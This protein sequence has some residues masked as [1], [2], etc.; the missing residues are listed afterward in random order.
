MCD[1]YI[2]AKQAKTIL[3]HFNHD[4]SEKR[5][6]MTILLTR[7][8]DPTK[9]FLVIESNLK[10]GDIE[11]LEY[12]MGNLFYFTS[13]N[14]TGH[15]LLNLEN[16]YDRK[17]AQLLFHQNN[18]DSRYAMDKMEQGLRS[19]VSQT[20]NFSSIRNCM[21]RN[22]PIIPDATWSNL[23]ILP[24]DGML[25]FDYVSCYKANQNTK[26]FV[27]SSSIFAKFCDG[28]N[29]IEGGGS[30]FQHK[31]GFIS[32]IAASVLG[33]IRGRISL[34]SLTG[35]K[36]RKAACSNIQ[37]W[38]RKLQKN[39]TTSKSIGGSGD[40]TLGSVVD[41]TPVLTMEEQQAQSATQLGRWYR[42]LVRKWAFDAGLPPS[43]AS[44][45]AN[46]SNLLS[47]HGNNSG[48][49]ILGLIRRAI[50]RQK[51]L[52][53]IKAKRMI[54]N[55]LMPL[56]R[57]I[58][59]SWITC[60][61]CAY[62]MSCFPSLFASVY[63]RV[64][65]LQICFSRIVDLENI[66]SHVFQLVLKNGQ[67]LLKRVLHV[68]GAPD[69]SN[70]SASSATGDG[71]GDVLKQPKK[72]K[73]PTREDIFSSEYEEAIH[74][75]GWLNLFNP[76]DPDMIFDLDHSKH[77]HYQLALMLV[78][79]ADIEPGENF[80]DETWTKWDKQSVDKLTGE[81]GCYVQV[82]GWELPMSWLSP[83]GIPDQGFLH[84]EYYS[85]RDPKQ[86]TT[87]NPRGPLAGLEGCS[88]VWELRQ[89]MMDNVLLGNR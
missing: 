23:R 56:R 79:L 75:I 28:L 65:V 13:N 72:I 55:G 49:G 33:M 58:S 71:G 34:A 82:P 5:K 53:K 85:G 40:G 18:D 44:A 42:A 67:R 39:R 83:G 36:L 61:Q 69:R 86:G 43:M 24:N 29:L 16:T 19:D 3:N 76:M 78:E 22:K 57:E 84:A 38:F 4:P 11:K 87:K 63:F 17:V 1:A 77:D 73:V 14:P 80:V 64:E 2:T 48:G 47:S 21:F 74:R 27:M 37:L 8:V 81:K 10:L 62:L 88:P 15:Y 52:D 45:R 59:K 35:K 70:S 30:S 12:K 60:K 41:N 31:P 46:P 7:L 51:S 26:R 54:A 89:R 9:K 25:E 20:G 50:V 32:S 68:G 6:V 66:W